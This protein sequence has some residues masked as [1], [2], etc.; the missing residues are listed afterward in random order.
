MS[1]GDR[2][3]ALQGDRRAATVYQLWLAG[4][5]DAKEKE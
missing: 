3:I 2:P 5:P 1:V 4:G